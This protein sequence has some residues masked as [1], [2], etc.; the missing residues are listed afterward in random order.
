MDARR[1]RFLR[2]ALDEKFDFFARRH[3]Q[4][5]KLVHNDHDLRQG[6][7]VQLLFFVDRL[8]AL[9]VISG[10]HAAPELFA[11]GMGGA[12]FFVVAGQ[13]PHADAGHHAIAIFHLL[14]RPFEGADRLGRFCHDRRQEMRDIV[15]YRKLQ[16]LGID[17]DHAAL[18]W[19][20]SI[21]Q[22]QDHAV[23]T[24]RLTRSGRARDQQMRHRGK[25]SNHGITCDI[26][27]QNDGKL[28]G[29][30][31]K[32]GAGRQF[33]ENNRFPLGIGKLN[34]NH[35]TARNGRDT[36]GE[37]RHVPRNII[38]QLDDTACLDA[39]FWLQLIHGDNR[40]GANLRD[41]ALHFEIIKDIFKEAGVA[42]QRRLIQRDFGRGWRC[43]Q[44]I[45]TGKDIAVFQVK[46]RLLRAFAQRCRGR[47]WI[48]DQ[49]FTPSGRHLCDRARCRAI[50][51]WAIFD[52]RR[53]FQFGFVAG[54]TRQPSRHR[55]T[56]AHQPC[57]L[58]GI[59][60]KAARPD[61]HANQPKQGDADI[62]DHAAKFWEGQHLKEEA[63]GAGD[64]EAQYT[65]QATGQSAEILWPEQRKRGADQDN[66]DHRSGQQT[67]PASKRC[68]APKSG[69][70][71][72]QQGEEKNDGEAKGRQQYV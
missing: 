22:R 2:Q 27:A 35:G 47:L 24:N 50:R 23:E 8:A 7:E 17:H 34:A 70:R 53:R 65:P 21:K 25:I 10:L 30:I 55:P 12:D 1:P 9:C 49:C 38:G 19:R 15:V 14:N 61:D 29:L 46:A 51:H 37:R 60:P 56:L 54:P 59:Q 63:G 64:G 44:Q 3:H 20:Q 4:I 57:P 41:H 33:M 52:K 48:D 16:H 11:F 5:G 43:R 72:H 13:A 71:H 39:A 42:F 40:A 26:L 18:V 31:G 28:R 69:G 6:A 62:M 67:P 66:P 45:E 58:I 32:C 68:A 36:S